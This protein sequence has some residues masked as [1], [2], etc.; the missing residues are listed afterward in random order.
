VIVTPH[1]GSTSPQS[2]RRSFDTVA[3]NLRRF[4]AGEPLVSV[5]DREAGY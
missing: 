2:R 4:A 5:V 3:G 1:N